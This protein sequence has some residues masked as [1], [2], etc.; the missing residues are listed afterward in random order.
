VIVPAAAGVLSAVGLALA[1]L[2]REAVAPEAVGFEALER[3]VALPGAAF[4]RLVDA[5]YRGQS[6]ELTVPVEGWEGA[7][8][9]AHERRYGYR[10][11]APVDLVSL[12]VRAVVTSE[13]ALPRWQETSQR[14]AGPE[15]VELE[16]ATC[17]VSEG[18]AGGTDDYGS[19]LL[20]RR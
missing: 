12:R 14:V 17:W 11:E 20:S 13:A 5:R 19:F 10:D 4:E 2:R 3:L 8:H 1:D 7:F 15:L 16:G 9:A 18:W 6:F